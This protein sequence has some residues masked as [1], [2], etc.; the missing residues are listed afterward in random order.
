V[1]GELDFIYFTKLKNETH[2]PKR[3]QNSI[4]TTLHMSQNKSCYYICMIIHMT[5]F[6]G[7]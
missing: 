6:D 7:R 4:L 2:T 5:I 1:R 3:P